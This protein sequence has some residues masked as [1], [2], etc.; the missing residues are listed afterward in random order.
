MSNGYGEFLSMR[1]AD[2]DAHDRLPRAL[3]H[4]THVAVGDWSAEAILD[5][6]RRGTPI[7]AIISI[8]AMGDRE[9][10]ITAYGPTH[11]EAARV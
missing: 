11:P 4:A 1:E 10:T 9:D 2:L 6:N 5:S 7:S 3:R 8:M